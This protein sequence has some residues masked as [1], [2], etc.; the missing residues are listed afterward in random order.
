MTERLSVSRRTFIAGAGAAATC[1]LGAGYGFSATPTGT[2]LHGLSAFGD[3]KYPADFHHFDYANLDAPKGGRFNFAPPNWAFNQ[4]VM[5]F[6]TLNSFVAKGDAPPRMELCFDSLM[7]GAL[8]E[9]DAVYGLLA[10]SVEIAEDRNAFTFRLRPEAHFHDDSAVTAADVAYSYELFREKGHPR[11]L[12]PLRELVKAEAIDDRTVRLSFTGRQ[13][14]RLIL[15]VVAFPVVSR[16]HFEA[17]PFDSSQV[18]APLGSGPYK[19]GRISAGF[20]IEYDRVADYWAADLPVNRGLNHFGT[21][22]IDFYRDRQA[23]FEAF[24]KGDVT[25]RQEFTSKTWATEYD[26]PALQDGKVIKREFPSEL[27]PAMQ[28]WAV[29]TRRKRFSDR[30]VRE[31]INL[32]FDFDWTRQNMFY[33]SYERSHSLFERSPYRAE[34]P[35][36][37]TERALLE[38]L[39]GEVPAEALGDA[40]ML[41][42]SDGSGRDRKLLGRAVKLL[43]EAGWTRKNGFFEN[44]AGERLALEIMVNAPVFVRVDTPFVEN[45]RAVGIDASVRL[46]DPAQF[47]ARMTDFDFDMVGIAFSF[48]ATPTEDSLEQFFHSRAADVPGSR[49][50]PGIADAAVDALIEKVGAASNRDDLTVAMRAL[51]RVLRARLD[52]IPNWHSANHRAAYWDMFG[53]DEP[54]PDYG[55]PVERLWWFDEAKARAI[56]KA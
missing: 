39:P 16:A 23:G 56:G 54:K 26:F 1:T 36:S 3:L 40:V 43:R 35:P 9:P 50:L 5:T 11:L 32:C 29:N 15:S 6:N 31:A 17:H 33:G 37:E 19:V 38:S 28:A 53:F 52:W 7:V 55:F 20:Y 25:Y 42:Q 4:N 30:R 41:P 2:P 22:R 12:L 51:D 21:I 47:Q 8:D 13:S 45:M 14:D 24:K 27:R 34:G 44:G 49:N 48:G 46:V 18:L 10:E